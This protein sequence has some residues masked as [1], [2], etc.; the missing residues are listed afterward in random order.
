MRACLITGSSGFCGWH[1]ARRLQAEGGIRVIGADLA[2]TPRYPEVLDEYIRAD[3]GETD[4][5]HRVL[6]IV[7]PDVVFH[8]AGASGGKPGDIF[9]ANFFSAL[10]LLE[11]VRCCFSDVRV[12]LVGSAAEYGEVA[13]EDLPVTEDT[14][15]RPV[16]PYGASKHA[17]TLSAQQ[18]ARLY[19]LKVVVA[20]PFNII[21]AGAPPHLLVGAILRRAKEAFSSG[22]PVIKVGNLES[23]R[24]FV[25]VEDVVEAYIRMGFGDF[26]GEIFN[27]CSGQP[28]SVR[29]VVELLLSH[30]PKAIRLEQDASLFRSSDTSIIYG[31]WEKSRK[32]FGFAPSVPLEA[33]LQE[34]WQHEFPG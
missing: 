2:E 25:A 32:A 6:Q 12:L 33:A 34:A 17:M 23:K 9:R 22:E 27:L 11:T 8:L 1:L 20:R 7:R 3:L 26:S 21:G 18:Y 30:S 31:D 13:P 15:C 10:H 29:S 19:R 16:D 5:I 28:R 4:A 24:D 14:D